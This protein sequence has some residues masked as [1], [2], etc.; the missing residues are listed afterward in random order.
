MH[1]EDFSHFQDSDQFIS[2]L[3]GMMKSWTYQKMPKPASKGGCFP[4]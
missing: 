4:S 1:P 2:P 3:E